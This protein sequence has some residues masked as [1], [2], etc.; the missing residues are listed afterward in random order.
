MDTRNAP[1]GGFNRS[2]AAPSTEGPWA[3]ATRAPVVRTWAP[4][5]RARDVVA[6]TRPCARGGIVCASTGVVEPLGDATPTAMTLAMSFLAG[7]LAGCTGKT[8]VAPFDRT[9]ILF[10]VSNKRFTLRGVARELRR[11]VAEEGVLALFKGNLATVMRVLPYSGIQLMSFDNIK[12]LVA[13]ARGRGAGAETDAVDRLV[14]GAGAGALSVAVTYPLDLMRARLAVQVSY[15][16]YSG[17]AHAFRTAYKE[18]GFTALYR[19]VG[20]TMLGILP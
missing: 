13:R 19:G 20:P 15:L 12:P 10:Q 1:R 14:A 7:G 6:A 16:H 2:G 17:L 3:A 9:K 4:C 5:A 8:V 18:E 11:I